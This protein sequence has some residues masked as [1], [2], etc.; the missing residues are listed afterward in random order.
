VFANQPDQ[1]VVDANPGSASSLPGTKARSAD[2]A[3]PPTSGGD[4]AAPPTVRSGP[5]HPFYV[6]RGAGRHL[7]FPL[8]TIDIWPLPTTS[9]GFWRANPVRDSTMRGYRGAERS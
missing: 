6:Y 2:P 9:C 3:W 8:A 4:P 1:V 5:A 7:R